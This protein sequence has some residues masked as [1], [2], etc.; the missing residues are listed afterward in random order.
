MA[1]FV[2][3]QTELKALDQ[4]LERI[5]AK[6]NDPEPGK[7]LFIRGRRRVGKSRLVEEF[8]RRSGVPSLFFTASR[9][10]NR[11]LDAFVSAIAASGFSA[12]EELSGTK[13]SDWDAAL[14]LLALALPDD[15]PS[16]VVIDEFPYL[17]EG[18]ESI[19]ATF[20]KMWDRVLQKKPLLLLLVG[21]DLAVM[22]M[23]NTHDRPLFQ[24]GTD[25]VVPP[26]TPV[27]VGEIIGAASAADAF[28]GYLLTGGMPM[29]C[30]EWPSGNGA[31]A[32]LETILSEPASILLTGAARTLEAEFPTDA[33]ARDVL[34]AIGSGERTFTNIKNQQQGL[35]DVS[36]TRSL[37]LLVSKRIVSRDVPLSTKPGNEPRYRIVDPYLQFW[38][39]F[40]GSHLDEIDRGRSDLVLERIRTDWTTWRGRAVEPIVRQALERL[41]T[42]Q[43]VKVGAVGAYWTRTNIPEV[44]IVVTDSTSK[45]RS[46]S[47]AGSIK[48]RE[49]QQFSQGDLVALAADVAKIPGA[50][51][52]TPLIAVGRAGVSAKGASMSFSADDL[53]EAWQ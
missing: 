30:D 23:L 31:L 44:D 27:E 12:T 4:A 28:D 17:I 11:E 16:V 20:Q 24:R 34:G 13:L 53:I 52:F 2:G 9:S 49:N 19:E 35:N 22:E 14:S 47:F 39:R 15:K 5:R 45:S 40:I 38:L 25:M 42:V 43:G 33:L 32:Y 48:W 18:D 50:N 21:S 37:D 3:R 8:L 29:L 41:L 6:A 46:I 26:L 36:L 10:V 51:H 1:G 7:L